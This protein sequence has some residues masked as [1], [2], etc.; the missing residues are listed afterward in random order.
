[1]IETQE[2]FENLDEIASTPG[3]DGLY[4]GT[5][6]LTIGLNQGKLVPGILEKS[7]VNA[8]EEM[9]NT[10]DQQ[11]KFEMH[12][13]MIQMTEELDSVGASLMRLPGM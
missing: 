7:N 9:V 10:I 2:A 11:R 3:L 4:I 1:M 5:A 8:V 12:V 13:K 6:D